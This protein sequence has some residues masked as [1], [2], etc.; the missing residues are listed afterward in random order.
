M[1]TNFAIDDGAL[2]LKEVARRRAIFCVVAPA[3]KAPVSRRAPKLVCHWAIDPLTGGL[4]ARWAEASP[5]A[6]ATQNCDQDIDPGRP[7]SGVS[8]LPQFDHTRSCVIELQ[9]A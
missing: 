9:A 1:I 5:D 3:A 7:G 6:G 4:S 8:L 2:R